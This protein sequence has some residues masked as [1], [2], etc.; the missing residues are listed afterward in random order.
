MKDNALH[1]MA[2]PH[3]HVE[4]CPVLFPPSDFSLPGKTLA[5]PSGGIRLQPQPFGSIP[6]TGITPSQLWVIPATRYATLVM[7][8]ALD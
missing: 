7:R 1:R 6:S 5:Q 3:S 4:S 2:L 8:L